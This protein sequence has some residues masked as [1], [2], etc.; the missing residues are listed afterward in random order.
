M[1]SVA[2]VEDDDDLRE[3]LPI[4]INSTPGFTCLSAYRDCETA[5]KELEND[6]PEVVL[7]DI[8]LPGMSGIEGIPKIKEKLPDIDIIMLTIH[9]DDDLVFDA[10]CAGACG[11]LLKD[12]PPEKILEAIREAHEGGAPMSSNIAR[13]VVRSFQTE[14]Y[15]PLT[16]RETGILTELCKGMSYKTIADTLFISEETVRSHIKHIYHKLHV[17]SKSEAV[18]KAFKSRLVRTTV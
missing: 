8:G 7:M 10:L 1:I 15:S 3:S 11:Y 9:E 2:I 13:M 14:H 4:L 6:L 17:R 18:A 12:T 5:I 16:K